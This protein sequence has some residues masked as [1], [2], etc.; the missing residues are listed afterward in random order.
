MLRILP[1]P[2]YLT[3]V[4]FVYYLKKLEVSSISIVG[5][6][7]SLASILISHAHAV[8]FE[9]IVFLVFVAFLCKYFLVCSFISVFVIR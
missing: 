9:K 5:M 2:Y 6:Y 8:I 3:L 7:S 1:M 4:S